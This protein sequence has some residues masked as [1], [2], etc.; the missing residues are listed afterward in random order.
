[1]RLPVRRPRRAAVPRLI[2]WA[3][4]LALLALPIG[5]LRATAADDPR[6]TP[7]PVLREFM[8]TGKYVFQAGET[9]DARASVFFSQR[10]AS[11]LVR[12]SPLGS[13]LLVRTG[14]QSVETFPESGILCRDDG[15]CDLRA[16][17]ET[18]TL[19]R[20]VVEG[21]DMVIRVPGLEA[22]LTPARPLKGWLKAATV[23]AHMP[24]YARDAKAHVP[25]ETCLPRLK[26]SRGDIRVFVYF[27]TWCPTCTVLMGRIL[28][29]EQELKKATGLRIQFDY[30][31]LPPSPNTWTDP[32]AVARDIDRIPSGLVYVDAQYAGRITGYEWSRPEAALLALIKP[33]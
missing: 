17:I 15:G 12:G 24:E 33:Q 25:D 32:E 16:D 27:G 23:L 5:G 13:P 1:M 14:T 3:A 28:R 6:P 19:G 26:A 2:A 21:S 9:V 22:K 7:H 11:Y 20:L 10:A 18:K 8:P 30:Y 29:L 31:A 4:G